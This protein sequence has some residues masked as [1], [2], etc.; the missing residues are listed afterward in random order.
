MESTLIPTLTWFEW[1]QIIR[2]SC[3][4]ALEAHLDRFWFP[5]HCDGAPSHNL[6][7]RGF[8][9]FNL[10]TDE[11]VFSVFWSCECCYIGILRQSSESAVN[12]FS[13]FWLNFKPFFW[14][15]FCTL[16]ILLIDAVVNFNLIRNSSASYLCCKIFFLYFDCHEEM[17]AGP[18]C[19]PRG[20][21]Q[22][23]GKFPPEAIFSRRKVERG[24][25]QGGNQSI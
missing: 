17:P 9:R 25:A 15:S 10:W 21:R 1:L 14:I 16:R 22:K 4:S 19:V 13:E 2:W 24:A 7:L 12:R 18:E 11:G 20:G 5:V 3:K 23:K 8:S 6:L